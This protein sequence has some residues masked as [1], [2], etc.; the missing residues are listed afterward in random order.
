MASKKYCLNH[1]ICWHIYHPRP[2][3]LGTWAGWASQ[4]LFYGIWNKDLRCARAC[5][6]LQWGFV[7]RSVFFYQKILGADTERL[8]E[9]MQVQNTCRV[10]GR[11]LVCANGLLN[12]PQQA[13]GPWMEQRQAATQWDQEHKDF[14]YHFLVPGPLGCLCS[15]KLKVTFVTW[16]S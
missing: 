16:E 14:H 3:K 10:Q 13:V 8:K 12:L 1:P 6:A 11:R 9:R 15:S 7:L 2:C 4:L 5:Q